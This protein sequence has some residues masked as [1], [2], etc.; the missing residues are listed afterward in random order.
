MNLKDS[1]L[2]VAIEHPETRK[3]IIPLIRQA[4]APDGYRP[5]PEDPFDAY[6][7]ED[8]SGWEIWYPSKDLAIRALKHH[9]QEFETATKE[10]GRLSPQAKMHDKMSR[11]TSRFLGQLKVTEKAERSNRTKSTR[12]PLDVTYDERDIAKDL[13]AKWDPDTR[14][15]MADPKRSDT[16]QEAIQRSREKA[17]H[18]RKD[19]QR[20]M[21]L[22]QREKDE[23]ERAFLKSLVPLIGNTYE[24]K[25]KIQAVGGRWD[26]T[27]RYW[28]VPSDQLAYLKGL[29]PTPAPSRTDTMTMIEMHRPTTGFVRTLNGDQWEVST[30]YP[31]RITSDDPA[32]DSRLLGHE[33]ER[34][35]KVTYAKV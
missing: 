17:E 5:I 19:L 4:S 8:R 29:I 10:F 24:I 6:K 11:A 28:L 9:D 25:D 27:H 23:R 35:F 30:I 33:G 2:R 34:A 16:I 13:G 26:A 3:H 18:F 7:M 22:K 21:D 12:V 14:R 20:D 31:Y 1:L 32:M 15:W